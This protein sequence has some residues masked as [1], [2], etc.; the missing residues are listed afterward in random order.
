M[1]QNAAEKIE[2][3][4]LEDFNSMRDKHMA[5]KQ[6]K[7]DNYI[8]ELT[9]TKNEKL[10]ESEN[11]EENDA[12][13]SEKKMASLQ[14]NPL[15][16]TS[17]KYFEKVE[18]SQSEK[19]KGDNSVWNL[20]DSAAAQL[21]AHIGSKRRSRSRTADKD[22]AIKKD[23]NESKEKAEDKVP[24]NKNRPKRSRR[25][26]VD[27]LL[28]MDFGPKEGGTLQELEAAKGQLSMVPR[29]ASLPDKRLTPIK[30][31]RRSGENSA[32]KRRAPRRF[33]IDD[34]DESTAKK[35]KTQE[36]QKADVAV[37][38]PDEPKPAAE[39]KKSV[40]VEETVPVSEEELIAA[41]TA[42][43]VIV[44]KPPTVELV[45][46]EKEEMMRMLE[47]VAETVE[48]LV[49][50][51]ENEIEP[52]MTPY[53]QVRM[54][55]LLDQEPS[56]SNGRRANEEPYVPS[57]TIEMKA[58]TFVPEGA[59]PDFNTW[60]VKQVHDWVLYLTNSK[61]VAD[62]FLDELI[63][64]S[65]FPILSSDEAKNDLKLPFGPRVKIIAGI[66]ALQRVRDDRLRRGN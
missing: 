36:V 33:A 53:D 38:Q 6:K 11:R 32:R 41:K 2:E 40:S 7:I 16:R 34:D 52:L 66:Q 64:G 8:M 5:E 57:T 37:N 21:K 47:D 26:E 29:R 31:E 43:P 4:P 48:D 22:V 56:T 54:R 9:A 13:E 30:V 44:K 39:E 42:R 28:R 65:I 23:D 49:L 24:Q 35:K 19:D 55:H 1:D 51:V 45:D 50:F 25:S 61:R 63:D 62:I 60:T 59:G 18:I 46:L 27:R 20:L 3:F 10:D 12:Q 17:R 58:I 15:K 14:P